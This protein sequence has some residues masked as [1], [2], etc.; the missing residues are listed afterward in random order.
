MAKYNCLLDFGPKNKPEKCN[1]GE[2]KTCGWEKSERER[3][4]KHVEKHGLTKC[5]DGL[6]RLIVSEIKRG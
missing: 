5:K 2:C 4:K 6:R 3:R 1:K